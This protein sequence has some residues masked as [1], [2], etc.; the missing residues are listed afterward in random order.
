MQTNVPNS[1][2]RKAESNFS[3]EDFLLRRK[4]CRIYSNQSIYDWFDDKG[5]S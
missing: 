2:E 1:I 3:E 4:N 5:S